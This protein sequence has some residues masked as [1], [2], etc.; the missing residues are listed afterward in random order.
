M[1]NL[2]IVNALK[3]ILPKINR[4]INRILIIGDRIS[5]N[6]NQLSKFLPNSQFF[7]ANKS[8]NILQSFKL[9]YKKQRNYTI[10]VIDIFDGLSLF[11][12]TLKYGKFDIVIVSG[13]YT[14]NINKKKLRYSAKFLYKHLLQFHGIFCIENLTHDTK[15]NQSPILE[16]KH[17][18]I[19]QTIET[20]NSDR[21]IFFTV[22]LKKNPNL[23]LG[24]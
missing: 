24:D 8:K 16:N 19:S 14:C 23:F 3:K 13:L 2:F 11:N 12:F 15:I 4:K 17:P 7:I 5:L 21:L 22:Y 6:Y 20:Q 9:D 10:Q 1:S 18:I